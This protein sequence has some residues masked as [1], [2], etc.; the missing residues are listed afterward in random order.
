MT[1]EPCGAVQSL[2]PKSPIESAHDAPEPE[3]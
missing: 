3:T 1:D 2:N